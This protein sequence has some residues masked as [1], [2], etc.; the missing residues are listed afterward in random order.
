[1]YENLNKDLVLLFACAM[2]CDGTVELPGLSYDG[3][4]RKRSFD[5]AMWLLFHFG[6]SNDVCHMRCVF[7]ST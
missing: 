4:P 1:M 6:F 3:L 7:K 5:Q 2:K